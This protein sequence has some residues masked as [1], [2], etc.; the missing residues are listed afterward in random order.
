MGN[1]SDRIVDIFLKTFYFVCYA[2]ILLISALLFL[3]MIAE[4][5]NGADMNEIVIHGFFLIYFISAILL[6]RWGIIDMKNGKFFKNFY[7]FSWL[8]FM[9]LMGFFVLFGEM[10]LHAPSIGQG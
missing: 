1:S 6:F 9:I 4:L 10:F 2:L 7:H 3:Q 5:T 8:I